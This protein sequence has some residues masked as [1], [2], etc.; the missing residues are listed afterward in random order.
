VRQA[1]Q[2]TSTKD[3]AIN[4]I[5]QALEDAEKIPAPKFNNPIVQ[6]VNVGGVK[7]P[8]NGS[9]DEWSDE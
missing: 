4:F 7:P 1:I 2:L 6:L 3:Q 5:V 9:N 8:P